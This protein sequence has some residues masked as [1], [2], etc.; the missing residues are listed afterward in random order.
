MTRVLVTGATGFVGTTLCDALGRSGY[1]VRAALRRDRVLPSCIAEKI[2]VGDHDAATD[3]SPALQGVDC[4]VHAAARAH[5]LYDSPA[6]ADLYFQTNTHGTQRLASMSALTGVRRFVY[7]SSIKVNGEGTFDRPYSADD[8]P[9]PIDDYGI[10]KWR[11]EQALFELAVTSRM[12]I[13]VIRPPLVYGPGV[14]ANFLRLMSWVHRSIPLPLASVTNARSMVSV[15]NLCDLVR[16]V[17]GAPAMQ[18][19]VLMVSDGTDLSTPDLI[20]RLALAMH[21]PVRLFPLHPG[22]L[23][24]AGRLTGKGAEVSRLLGSL[25]VDPA[26]TRNA[27]GW[28]PPVS[29]DEGLSRTV[30]WYLEQLNARAA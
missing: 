21:R 5:I 11:A 20:R 28:T 8:A 14:R 17:L 16:C 24:I 9:S 13:A 25:Q 12:E 30:Q 19:C 18:P 3:W 4:V 27:L 2:V 6:N 23:R 15:W 26:A 1:L 10:S 7:L 29:V 22:A